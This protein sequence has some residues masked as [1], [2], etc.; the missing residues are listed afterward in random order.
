MN[1]YLIVEYEVCNMNYVELDLGLYVHISQWNMM[2]VKWIYVID[3]DD[4]TPRRARV[5]D[6]LT[7]TYFDWIC[8]GRCSAAPS[9][10]KC[11]RAMS[12]WGGLSS[13]PH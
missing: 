5:L 7:D 11:D 8:S 12:S 1:M 3:N 10:P 4:D 13:G 9:R 2:E 6:W